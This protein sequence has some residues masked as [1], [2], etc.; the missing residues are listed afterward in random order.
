MTTNN[1][2]TSSKLYDFSFL[3]SLAPT[4]AAGK[5]FAD[6]PKEYFKEESTS[7][8]ALNVSNVVFKSDTEKRVV[9]F[10]FDKCP[11]AI[12][13]DRH[14]TYSVEV[15]DNCFPN[16]TRILLSRLLNLAINR[17]GK[18]FLKES[19]LSLKSVACSE[20]DSN[21][22]MIDYLNSTT[23]IFTYFYGYIDSQGKQAEEY[24]SAK[25]RFEFYTQR[26]QPNIIVSLGNTAYSFYALHKKY[27]VAV[28]AHQFYGRLVKSNVVFN[29]KPVYILGTIDINNALLGENTYSYSSI[30]GYA[31]RHLMNAIL[32]TECYSVTSGFTSKS[33]LFLENAVKSQR[34]D[35]VESFDDLMKQLKTKKYVAIDTETSNLNRVQ[36]TI[37]TIQFGWSA[38]SSFIVPLQHFE[39]PFSPRDL[40][41]IFSELIKFF[42]GDNNNEYHIYTN[43][44]FDLN[45]LRSVVGVRFFANNV[46]DILAAEYALD[47]NAKYFSNVTGKF[48][49]SLLNL[50]LFYGTDIYLTAPFSKGQRATISSSSLTDDVV[51]YCCYDVMVPYAIHLMQKKRAKDIAYV[52]YE[53][54]VTKQLSDM[55]LTFSKME[56]TGV[57]VDIDYLMSLRA[58]DSPIVKEIEKMEMGIIKTPAGIEANR[59]LLSKTGMPPTSL[60]GNI[61][62]DYVLFSLRKRDHLALLFFDVLKLDQKNV[63]KSGMKKIDAAFQS[64]YADN[65]VV[66]MYTSLS[67]SKK[68]A[69]SYVKQFLKFWDTSE[70]FR[71]DSR[72]RPYYGML[73]VVT[74]RTSASK[75][76]L[77]Q[78]PARTD[79]GKLIKRLF[80]AEENCLYIKVDFSSH[81]VRNWAIVSQDE[82]VS[83]LFLHGLDLKAQ[84]RACPTSVLKD[85][86]DYEAD[87]HKLNA[88]FFFGVPIR[89]VT[90]DLRNSVKSVIFGLIY[91]LGVNKM[92][93][94]VKKTVEETL[95]LIDQFSSRFHVGWDWFEGVRKEASRKLYV[96]SPIGRRRNLFQYMIP[97]G[98]PTTNSLHGAADRRAVNSVIQGLSSDEALIA[99]R[100]IDRL[101]WN[102]Y[103][104]NKVLTN[105][106]VINMVHDSIEVEVPYR[107][108]FL[109]LKFIDYATTLGV[110]KVVE[111]RAGFKLSVD[112]DTDFEIGADGRGMSKWDNS[113]AS[114]C[115]CLDKALSFQ[116]NDLKRDIDVSK[117]MTKILSHYEDGPAWLVS[118]IKSMTDKK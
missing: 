53:S 84:Y 20:F 77:Q 60:F 30:L 56:S 67:K 71:Q 70:D 1:V 112:L 19:P 26:Y 22:D 107:Y 33:R 105:I 9:M 37:Q 39:T 27:S 117:T 83:K 73:N 29:E 14:R 48:Y 89:E 47:E 100:L 66:S 15:P 80:I 38:T 113:Y 6:K 51:A 98:T 18:A 111:N 64:A 28:F 81:E 41:Y 13:Q 96:E 12:S 102:F 85:R 49:Y 69:S 106:R 62:D 44:V 110:R 54:V 82:E 25:S 17:Y 52:N 78:I 87:V 101:V 42:E 59:I 65:P 23:W 94:Q 21:S 95:S 103:L 31:A 8:K 108:F 24:D 90:K 75:P 88:S 16:H 5:R 40:T 118:Q 58:P 86:I 3:T 92:S 2:A 116:K 35:T 11:L 91:G 46:W 32:G 4:Y 114:L 74:G 97:E 10:V 104:K 50:S 76:S 45:V 79:L 43:A 63:G 61:R 109:A 99:A 36:N 57:L 7:V 34:I 68:L 72:V 115:S 55:L 93:K